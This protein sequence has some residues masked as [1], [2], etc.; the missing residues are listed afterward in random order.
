MI[1]G[2]LSGLALTSKAAIASVVAATGVSPNALTL[3]G[4]LPMVVATIELARSHLVSAAI[5]VVVAGVIDL[6]DGAVAR[7]SGKT[8]AFGGILDSTVDRATDTMIFLGAAVHFSHQGETLYVALTM[9]ALGGALSTSYARA[10]SENVIAD[11]RVGFAERGERLTLLLLALLV[12]RLQQAMWILAVI[13]WL[14]T[15]QR[16]IH[17]HRTIRRAPLP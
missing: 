13:T 11:C 16:L 9:V 6:L 4:V 5:W 12:N 3:L 15:L 17:A 14:T 2:R 10:R 7:A 1:S 8:S